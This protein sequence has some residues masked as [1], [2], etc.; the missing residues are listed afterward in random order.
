MLQLPQHRT[1]SRQTKAGLSSQPRSVIRANLCVIS[2]SVCIVLVI[3]VAVVFPESF[4]F[5][6]LVTESFVTAM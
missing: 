5:C 2:L 4:P 1:D 3:P 6:N